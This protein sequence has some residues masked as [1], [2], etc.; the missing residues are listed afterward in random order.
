MSAIKPT[1]GVGMSASVRRH[2]CRNYWVAKDPL[3]VGPR[4]AATW[5]IVEGMFG[6]D[7]AANLEE[8]RHI[9]MASTRCQARTASCSRA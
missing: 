1:F 5:L 7:Q 3:D 4:Y 9:V 8:E 2:E 6:I